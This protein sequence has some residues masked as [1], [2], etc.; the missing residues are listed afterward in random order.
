MGVPK[1]SIIGPTIFNLFINDI[2]RAVG[3]GTLYNYA[4]DNTILVKACTKREVTNQ[5]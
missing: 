5:N 3:C 1:G 2:F 4:D